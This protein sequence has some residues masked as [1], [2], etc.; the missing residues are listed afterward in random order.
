M[1]SNLYPPAEWPLVVMT[2]VYPGP[3]GRVRVADVRTATSSYTRPS[4]KLVFLFS[5]IKENA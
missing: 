3:D 2:V 5:G 1:K 4:A